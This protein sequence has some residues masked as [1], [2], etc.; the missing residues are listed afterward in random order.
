MYLQNS[1]LKPRFKFYKTP[2]KACFYLLS[3]IFCCA[4]FEAVAADWTSISQDKNSEMLVDM[5]SYNESDGLPYISSKTLFLKP[6]NDR[7]NGLNFSYSESRS[8]TQFNCTLHTFKDN[9]TQFYSANKKLVGNKKSDGLFKPISA[10][11]KY[12]ALESLVCQVHKM[13]GGS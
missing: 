1:A 10:G 13:V 8:T 2:Q 5:D 12:A 6:Q 9:A 3:T 11:S 7:K 4:V